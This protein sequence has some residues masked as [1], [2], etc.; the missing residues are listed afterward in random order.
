[1]SGCK[2]IFLNGFFF[3]KKTDVARF[4]TFR[5]IEN[6][7]QYGQQECNET[8]TKNMSKISPGFRKRTNTDTNT[9]FPH[10]KLRLN[11]NMSETPGKNKTVSSK[12][13]KWKNNLSF[14]YLH[15]FVDIQNIFSEQMNRNIQNPQVYILQFDNFDEFV[16]Q[17]QNEI[18]RCG[19]FSVVKFVI[20]KYGCIKYDDVKPN[21]GKIP[22]LLTEHSAVVDDLCIANLKITQLS[23]KIPLAIVIHNISPDSQNMYQFRQNIPSHAHFFQN[24]VKVEKTNVLEDTCS[25]QPPNIYERQENI[26]QKSQTLLRQIGD[27]M[28]KIENNLQNMNTCSVPIAQETVSLD[29][30][31][32]CLEKVVMVD[33]SVSCNLSDY[34]CEL[35][36]C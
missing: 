19:S 22:I 9:T 4:D 5:N 2:K 12:R 23:L 21:Y 30:D 7:E 34:G 24:G 28:M 8:Q 18:F 26:L 10:K 16:T 14:P 29:K 36:S 25:N 32:K 17:L 33:K 35:T 13:I 3:K 20:D 27:S 1:M 15:K 6:H 11:K 31:C